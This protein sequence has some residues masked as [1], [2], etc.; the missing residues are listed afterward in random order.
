MISFVDETL[1]ERRSIRDASN[2]VGKAE[3]SNGRSMNSVTV[4]IRIASANETESP[5]SEV[6]R[7]TVR[8]AGAIRRISVAVLVDG[9]TTVGDDG[10]PGWEPRR[11][12]ELTALRGLV[13]AAIGFDEARG[14]IVTVESMAFQPDATPGALVEPSLMLRFFER[15]AMTLI[16]IGVLSVV[17]LVLALTVVR[18]ILTRPVPAVPKVGQIAGAIDGPASVAGAHLDAA[19]GTT[20]LPKPNQPGLPAPDAEALR[21][22]IAERP[23]QTVSMLQEWLGAAEPAPGQKEVA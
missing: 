5:R 4:K 12:A 2:T 8:Q 20:A 18:P 22:A 15:N 13:V 16:Q 7:Q 6:Q 11:A 23:E 3:K 9:I 17:V 10:G 21:H 19:P 1:S 14:D